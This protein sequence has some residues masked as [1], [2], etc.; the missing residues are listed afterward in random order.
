ME[1]ISTSV[2]LYTIGC[3]QCKVLERKL[4]DAKISYDTETDV[5]EMKKMGISTLPILEVDGERLT[6]AKAIE[7]VREREKR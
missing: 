1:V 6:F 5:E 2:K 7:W 3:P 4:G